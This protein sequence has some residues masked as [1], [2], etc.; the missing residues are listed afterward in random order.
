MERLPDNLARLHELIGEGGFDQVDLGEPFVV[1]GVEFVLGYRHESTADRFYMVKASAMIECYRVLLPELRGGVIFE[2]GI[3]EGGS[4]VWLALEAEPSKLIAIDNE[5]VALRALDELIE[6][7]GLGDVIRPHW[8]VD[9]SDRSR[10]LQIVEDEIGDGRLD[11]VIDDA[12]H[13]LGPTRSSFETLFPLVRPG[14]TYLIEDWNSAHVFADAMDAYFTDA[15]APDH[16]ERVAQLR[17]GF[18]DP[19]PKPP[20]PEP[21]SRI[22]IE[23]M[24]ARASSGDA[25][26]EVTVSEF[27]VSVRRG[28]GS[29]DPSTFR[30]RDLYTDH[31]ALDPSG[32]RPD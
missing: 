25:V 6:A 28:P 18:L 24:L 14:G 20:Q 12:S 21:L 22:A 15:S 9:Q 17:A 23:L 4:T 19:T 27:F 5:P 13:L 30:L 31:F 10:L 11:L 16:E 2:L 1:D 32:T 8:G 29:L 7:R 26:E 3:A